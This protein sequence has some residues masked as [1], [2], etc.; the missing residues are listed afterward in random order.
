MHEV[1]RRDAHAEEE[2]MTSIASRM[3]ALYAELPRVACKRLCQDSCAAMVFR[4]RG[5]TVFEFARATFGGTT[6]IPDGHPLDL[7]TFLRQGRCSIY[8]QRPLVCR[9]WGVVDSPK[10]RCPHGCEPE[11]WLTDAEA[12]ALIRRAEEIGGGSA[13][14]EGAD[15]NMRE[16]YAAIR[17]GERGEQP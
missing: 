4:N 1:S 13:V 14:I 7:C 10:M 16:A 15:D 5:M 9:L 17:R 3:A 12:R 8:N 2:A 6:P 11:W